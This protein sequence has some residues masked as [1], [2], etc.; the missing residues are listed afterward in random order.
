MI[1]LSLLPQL[2][3]DM[4]QWR[5][6]LHQYPETAFEENL[7]ADFIADKLVEFGLE[8]HRG[9]A[10]TGV[11]ATLMAGNGGKKI[12]LRADMDALFIQ[13]QN[14]FAHKS[15]H[16]GKMHACG[17]DGH[18]A[19]LL[20]AAKVLS[21]RCDFSGTVYFIF[22]PAEEGR[23]GAKAMIDDGLFEQFPADCVFGMHNFPDIPAGHFAVKSKAMMAALD[24][25]EII[26]NGK[27]THAAMPHLGKDVIVAAAQLINN[28]QTIVSRTVNPA[29]SAVVTITQIH[30]GNT[31]NGIP[32]S[33]VLRG[34]FRCF[35]ATV[36][37]LITDKIGQLVDAVCAAFGMSAEFKLNPE[38]PGYPVTYNSD[39]ETA[40]ALQAA[41]AVVGEASVHTN[42]TPSMGSED[43][44][45]MLQ[46]K[47]GCYI[48]IGNGSSEN[49][50]L[51]HNPHYDFNDEI[52]MIGATYWV[53]LVEMALA[54]E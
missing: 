6:H 7:T 24:S 34:T 16:D 42:P 28:L 31:W 20:G 33:V 38:N 39:K 25:F 3:D 43:F 44:A 48:W 45:F 1:D 12:A 36:Q 53:K 14:A 30:A 9:L 35:D 17:H 26:L 15:K 22:Q 47:P 41:T 52:L 10:V 21:Q 5:R 23:A 46:E 54:I 19:M 11:V 51:L 40:L 2:Q 27:A 29:D 32:D 37:T 50:C 8:V 4:R 18:S 49:S 13:E